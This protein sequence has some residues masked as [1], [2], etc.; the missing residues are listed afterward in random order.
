MN[1]DLHKIKSLTVVTFLI[2]CITIVCPGIM[3]VFLFSR[4]LFLETDTFKL[5]LLSVS[6]TMP[7]SLINSLM[8]GLIQ[9]PEKGDNLDDNLQLTVILGN[10]I[11]LPII[12]IPLIVKL[13]VDI[14]L[15]CGVSIIIVL[16]I[17]IFIIVYIMEKLHSKSKRKKQ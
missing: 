4:E 11:S 12:Y 5:I 7:I 8:I 17:A 14:S 10:I 1:L 16:Q 9:E 6:I 15:Q 3:F 13:F 2:F